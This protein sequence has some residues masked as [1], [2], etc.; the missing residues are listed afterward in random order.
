M[1]LHLLRNSCVPRRRPVPAAQRG[2]SLIEVL[3]TMVLT[4]IGMLGL[5]AAMGRTMQFS[6]DTEDRGRAV[7]LADELAAQMWLNQS[8]TLPNGTITAWQAVA[9]SPTNGRGLPGIGSGGAAGGTVTVVGGTATITLAWKSPRKLATDAASTYST[10]V[11]L[12]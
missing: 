9:A 10:Q 11:T 4:S 5:V 12:P 8:V 6:V 3:V 2:M 7:L 1:R